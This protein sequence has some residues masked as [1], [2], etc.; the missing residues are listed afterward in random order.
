M[1]ANDPNFYIP[2]SDARLP[3]VLL[4]NLTQA[5]QQ[6]CNVHIDRIRRLNFRYSSQL[7]ARTELPP[8]FSHDPKVS[9][10]LFALIVVSRLF[11]PINIK[12]ADIDLFAVPAVTKS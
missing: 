5:T 10:Q 4:T 6:I 1:S 9:L 2:V 8:H 11:V 7:S 12:V 3:L